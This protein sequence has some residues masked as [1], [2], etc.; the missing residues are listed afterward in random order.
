MPRGNY[1]RVRGEYCKIGAICWSHRELPPRARRILCG[2]VGFVTIFGTTSA[3]AENTHL[4]KLIEPQRGNYLRVRGEYKLISI[5][6]HKDLELPPRARRI[7]EAE[8]KEDGKVGTTSACAENTL[9]I[10]PGC[11]ASGNYLRVRGEYEMFA[12]V[13]N[14]APELPPR[15]RRIPPYRT[16]RKE[17]HGTTSACAENTYAD[18]WQT[19]TTRNYLRVRGEYPK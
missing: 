8:S 10:L 6:I 19:P 12:R 11:H 9:S 3:C 4:G 18:S 1:L 14:A 17:N 16:Y 15:A 13:A 5:G 7:P 2:S